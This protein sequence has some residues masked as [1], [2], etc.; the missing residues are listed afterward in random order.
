M[1]DDLVHGAV[2]KIEI[3]KFYDGAQ[4][5]QR[6]ANAQ[7]GEAGFGNGCIPDT[8]RVKLIKHIVGDMKGANVVVAAVIGAFA[9]VL[10]VAMV[11][12]ALNL[13]NADPLWVNAV[14]G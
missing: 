7:T 3:L 13:M 10:F 4:A 2:D 1:I 8:M 6:G 12:N 9:G 5:C 14:R 11:N